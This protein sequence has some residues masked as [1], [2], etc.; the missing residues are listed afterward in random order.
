MNFMSSLSVKY[1]ATKG[2]E[3]D[4]DELTSFPLIY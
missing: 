4:I 3:N 2:V 1:V